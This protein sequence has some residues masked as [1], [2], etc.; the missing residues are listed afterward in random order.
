MPLLAR[1][2]WLRDTRFGAATSVLVA[3]SSALAIPAHADEFEQHHA[4]EH[5]KVTLN[6]ALDG[7]TFL[8][9]LDAPAVNVVGFEHPPRTASEKAAVDQAAQLLRKG[10][11]LLGFPPAAAC[12]F[13]NTDFT[14]PH[15]EA[16]AQSSD[17]QHGGAHEAEEHADYEAKFTFRCEH[18][19]ALGWFEPWL[20]AKL[21]HVTEA[22]INLITPS[23]QRSESVTNA[24]ARVSLS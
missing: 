20:L 22:R 4:H 7:P 18:P 21:L 11:S 23:G 14:E 19:E 12:H 10:R 13:V 3:L 24:R 15:W 5:G 1:S 6:A 8:V 2:Q 9:E 17:A 16:P